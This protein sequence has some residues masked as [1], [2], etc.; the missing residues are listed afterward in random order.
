MVF[1]LPFICE[2]KKTLEKNIRCNLIKARPIFANFTESEY[3]DTSLKIS[4]HFTRLSKNYTLVFITGIHVCS[5]Q[6]LLVY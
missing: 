4:R 5:K 3:R 6:C 2:H 1:C